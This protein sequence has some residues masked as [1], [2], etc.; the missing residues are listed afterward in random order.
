MFHISTVPQTKRLVKHNIFLAF[1]YILLEMLQY[2]TV[3]MEH[4][5]RYTCSIAP[6]QDPDC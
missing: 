1:S 5:K 3:P 2:I 4:Y 6:D